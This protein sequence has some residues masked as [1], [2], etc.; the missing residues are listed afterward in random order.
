MDPD[1]ATPPEPN[2]PF[3]PSAEKSLSEP[4]AAPEPTPGAEPQQPADPTSG[5]AQPFGDVSATPEGAAPAPE[6]PGNQSLPGQSGP[7]PAVQPAS[8]NGDPTP[9][10][11]VP[12]AAPKPPRSS[13]LPAIVLAVVVI[14]FL[15]ALAAYAFTKMR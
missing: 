3:G 7:G 13:A 1:N 9:A 2:K 8:Q 11:P 10:M 4:T 15:V 6:T 5:S 12:P 14:V